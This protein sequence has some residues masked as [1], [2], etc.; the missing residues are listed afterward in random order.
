MNWFQQN[1]NLIGW[2]GGITLTLSLLSPI[3]VVYFIEKLPADYFIQPHRPL[4]S[5]LHPLSLLKNLL[6]LFLVVV[7]IAMLLLP[8]Q[9]VLTVLVGLIMMNFPGK[10]KLER[11][12]LGL[13][14]V[15]DAINWIRKKGGKPPFLLEKAQP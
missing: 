1:G 7:G 2:V 6:G 11:W 10:K 15:A 13:P 4:R 9:G 3:A 5:R 12:L 8:G 14:K